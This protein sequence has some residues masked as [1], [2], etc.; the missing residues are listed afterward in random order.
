VV[1]SKINSFFLRD[2]PYLNKERINYPYGESLYRATGG[3]HKGYA[4][5]NLRDVYNKPISYS[6]LLTSKFF[7]TTNFNDNMERRAKTLWDKLLEKDLAQDLGN[8]RIQYDPYGDYDMTGYLTM[9]K[10]GG[11]I[12]KRK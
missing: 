10:K 7:S 4:E 5:N 2:S 9:K 11:L 8:K 6:P 12:K 1:D 3:A